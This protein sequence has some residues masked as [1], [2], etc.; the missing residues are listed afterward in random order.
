V[1][2]PGN[3]G[4][5]ESLGV[6]FRMI[7]DLPAKEAIL[8]RDVSFDVNK[9]KHAPWDTVREQQRGQT[10]HGMADEV[11]PFYALPLQYCQCGAHQKWDQPGAS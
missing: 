1:K 3:E 10:A 8:G 7:G 6:C 5:K 11:E 9:T 4:V 2:S